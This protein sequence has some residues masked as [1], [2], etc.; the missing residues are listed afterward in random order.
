MPDPSR[1]AGNASE[2]TPNTLGDWIRA[3]RTRLQ[4]T[5]EELAERTTLVPQSISNWEC[6]RQF[7][8]P[9]AVAALEKVFGKPVPRHLLPA[10]KRRGDFIR[11]SGTL[12]GLLEDGDTLPETY[13]W[14]LELASQ[15]RKAGGSKRDVES[16]RALVTGTPVAALTGALD[17]PDVTDR[18]V[19]ALLGPIGEAIVEYIKT[20]PTRSDETSP[21]SHSTRLSG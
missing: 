16:A 19:L 8:S 2:S 5:Q 20:R 12:L 6:S 9:L 21:A 17:H 3:E 11:S 7:P 4:L 14:W 15:I 13:D 10:V 1:D 18:E